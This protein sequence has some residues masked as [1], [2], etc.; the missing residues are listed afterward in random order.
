MYICPCRGV[1]FCA[2]LPKRE[3]RIAPPPFPLGKCFLAVPSFAA[4]VA[5]FSE[6]TADFFPK[7]PHRFPPRTVGED[8]HHKMCRSEGK[9]VIFVDLCVKN[10]RVSKKKTTFA[11]E[12]SLNLLSTPPCKKDYFFSSWRCSPRW[13][14]SRRRGFQNS[15]AGAT[16]RGI[17]SNSPTAAT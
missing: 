11:V 10:A 3:K 14:R 12:L 16:S 15:V 7:R 8:H 17:S 13:R 1:A 9:S 5:H 2:H 4:K 6:K